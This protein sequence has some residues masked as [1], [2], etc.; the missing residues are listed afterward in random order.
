M[1]NWLQTLCMCKKIDFSQLNVL[2]GSAQRKSKKEKTQFEPSSE[3]GNSKH[4][5][6]KLKL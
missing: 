1:K 6:K 4:E 2:E 3:L 5:N